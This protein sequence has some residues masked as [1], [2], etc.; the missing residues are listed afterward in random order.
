MLPFLKRQW[1]L[2]AVAGAALLAYYRPGWGNSLHQYDILSY[3]IFLSFFATGLSLDPRSILRQVKAVRAP[4]A[5]LVSSLLLYPLLA[6]AA[7]LPLL[8]YEFVIGICIVGTAPVTISSGTIMT[9]I[10]RG[11][12][13]LSLLIC[14][15]SNF[16]AIFTIP[17][18]LNLLLGFAGEIEL[19]VTQMLLALLLKILLPLI[20]GNLLRPLAR[21]LIKRRRQEISIFQSLIIVLIIFNVVSS[22]A[23][24]MHEIG[25]S[26][27]AVV[28][29]MVALNLVILALNYGLAGLIRLDRPATIAFTIHTSQKTLAVS[30]IVWAGYF[31]ADYPAALVP[32]ITGQL[33][34]M[35]IGTL[36]ANYF[37]ARN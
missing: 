2:I 34:Q 35:V 21:E 31:A 11:N 30:Y 26:L 4:A 18:M 23:E 36:V 16:L 32:A 19:P 24:K 25:G 17:L 15:L 20:L 9:T 14:I 1:F 7:A 12:I 29:F 10:A 22:S 28:L 33:V 27:A 6:W 37:R 3:G 8:P 13:P 5:A